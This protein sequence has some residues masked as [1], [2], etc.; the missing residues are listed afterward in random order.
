MAITLLIQGNQFQFFMSLQYSFIDINPK[1]ENPY[2]LKAGGTKFN[3]PL[4]YEKNVY[5]TPVP[6]NINIRCQHCSKLL[7]NKNSI[8]HETRLK[9]YDL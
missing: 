7:F 3:C 2:K 4:C 1:N 6:E 9:D 8:M 5:L